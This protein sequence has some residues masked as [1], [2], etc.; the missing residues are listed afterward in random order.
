MEIG[1]DLTI[2]DLVVL[3]L[4]LLLVARGLW[5]GFLR[6][7]ISLVALYI[8]YIVASRYHDRLF[9][10][11]RELSENP[12]VVFF[13]SYAILFVLTY[14]LAVLAGKGLQYVVKVSMAGWF[15]HLLGG[16]LGFAKGILLVVLMHM[17]LGTVL[18]PENQLLR[19]CQTCDE[20]S[21]ATGLAVELVSNEEARKALMQQMPAISVDSVKEYLAPAAKVPVPGP[22]KA[23]SAP[24]APLAAPAPPAQSSARPGAT[25]GA[26]SFWDEAQSADAAKQ[27]P[28]APPAT[29]QPLPR[30]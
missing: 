7:I 25:G 26:A 28:A 20:L 15:D 2:Y 29:S 13:V 19:N 1:A 11:L 16:F 18:A 9:P 27:L 30:Q 4:L 14:I 12:E 23:E 3:G 24:P 8:G 17:V 6:Q 22:V 21:A 5:V 10:F